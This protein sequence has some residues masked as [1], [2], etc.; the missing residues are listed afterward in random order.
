MAKKASW[1]RV[2]AKGALRGQRFASQADYTRALR[3]ARRRKAPARRA[4]VQGHDVRRVVKAY[5]VLMQAGVGRAK[6]LDIIE[7]LVS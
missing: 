2:M 3:E 1:P 5:E 4:L 6:S 7:D